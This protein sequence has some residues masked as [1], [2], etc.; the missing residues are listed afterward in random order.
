VVGRQTLGPTRRPCPPLA[1]SPA[2]ITATSSHPET[3]GKSFFGHLRRAVAA[4][5]RRKTFGPCQCDAE[6]P[7]GVPPARIST[8][9]RFQD[10]RAAPSARQKS[11]KADEQALGNVITNRA[12]NRFA[13]G[14]DGRPSRSRGFDSSPVRALTA[15][16]S[17]RGR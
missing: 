5:A 11:T 8:E 4:A 17:L 16:S 13:W 15:G 3:A 14:V 2:S 9:R 10:L 12:N 6:M 1:R 7:C